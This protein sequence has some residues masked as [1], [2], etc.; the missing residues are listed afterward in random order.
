[1]LMIVTTGHIERHKQGVNVL[2][3]TKH[4]FA[5]EDIASDC[6]TE[7]HTFLDIESKNRAPLLKA[8]R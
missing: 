7:R 8:T 4:L 6:L 2:E 5:N 3:Y 1:M